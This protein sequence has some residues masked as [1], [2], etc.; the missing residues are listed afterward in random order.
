MPML[1]EDIQVPGGLYLCQAGPNLSCGSCCG[2]YN[3]AGLGREQLRAILLER[4]EN[5]ASTPRNVD[6]ILAFE[7]ERMALEGADYPIADFHH[8]VFVGLIQDG[9]ERIGCLLHPLATGNNGVDWRGL[10]FYG[11]A[12]CKLFF[13][14]SYHLGEAR[15]KRTVREVLDD[16]F[17]YGLIVP[18]YRLNQA[19]L[20]EVETRAGRLVDP[21]DMSPEV[22]AALADLFR[23]RIDWPFRTPDTPL[24]WNFFSTKETDRPDLL[25]PDTNLEPRQRVMLRELQ[26]LPEHV[27]AGLVMI[28]E[29]IDRAAARLRD[30]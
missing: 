11:G 24:A 27:G 22:K 26:T 25:G 8:C 18:E 30:E 20:E 3:M 2:L 14:P 19:L 1:P 21:N 23:L 28:G 16:W 4:T 13:C 9:G 15:W 12:A 10:S 6:A 7:Q 17:D 5:F 29:R